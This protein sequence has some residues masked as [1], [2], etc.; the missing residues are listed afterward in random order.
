MTRQFLIPIIARP[1][2]IES[3]K[4]HRFQAPIVAPTRE[5]AVLIHSLLIQT[6]QFHS[7]SSQGQYEHN[8]II[9]QLVARGTEAQD[10]S[11]FS[12]D[13]SN[14]LIGTPGGFRKLLAS[15]HIH[16]SATRVLVL[17]E[18]DK[19]L[20]TDF[21]PDIAAILVF[22]PKQRQTGLFNASMDDFTR[23]DRI[24]L[25]NPVRVSVKRSRQRAAGQD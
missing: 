6:L 25:R 14:L 7:S 16:A 4:K 20:A 13:S 3:S 12:S 2:G 11:T 8:R 21:K 19:L 24:G 18:A 10:L 9:P 5:L 15:P 17:D 1:P 22:L 23:L